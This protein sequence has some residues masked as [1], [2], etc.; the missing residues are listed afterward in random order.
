M[1]SIMCSAPCGQGDDMS[2]RRGVRVHAMQMSHWLCDF[3]DIILR[4]III[5]LLMIIIVI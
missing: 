4:N 5:T 3:P 1:C 2:E